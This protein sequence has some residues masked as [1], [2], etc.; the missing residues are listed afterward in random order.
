MDYS[1][2]TIGALVGLVIA[3]VLIIKPYMK[4][5]GDRFRSPPDYCSYFSSS[6]IRSNTEARQPVP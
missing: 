2:T 4:K 6:S 3:I 1:F 5:G